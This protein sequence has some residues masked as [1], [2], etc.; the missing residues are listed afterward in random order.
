[1]FGIPSL[2]KYAHANAW[3]EVFF[4]V[5]PCLR[6][7]H[8]AAFA[9]ITR[10]CARFPG[11]ARGCLLRPAARVFQPMD[12]LSLPAPANL[13]PSWP[14]RLLIIKGNARHVNQ[15]LTNFAAFFPIPQRSAPFFG[16]DGKPDG[17]SRNLR[18]RLP[19]KA[20]KT[21]QGGRPLQKASPSRG[22]WQARKQQG[23]RPKAI[24]RL[25]DEVSGWAETQKGS[26]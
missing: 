12:A 14:V 5:P 1:M 8:R 7:F 21:A 10:G 6:G 16:T 15:K 23:K 24:S 11:K 22:S 25:T 2:K 4:A 13:V 3:D 26:M 20:G 19:L 17:L 9:P 18:K